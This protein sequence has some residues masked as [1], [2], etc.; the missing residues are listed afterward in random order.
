MSV[1][2]AATDGFVEAIAEA[3]VARLRSN[4]FSGSP[5][6]SKLLSVTEAAKYLGWKPSAVRHAVSS[7]AIPAKV[8]KRFGRRV[9]LFREELDRWL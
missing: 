1:V 7:G 5:A 2:R 3:V 4:G 9:F 8:I 6:V